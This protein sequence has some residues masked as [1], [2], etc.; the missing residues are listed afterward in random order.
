MMVVST[1]YR[2]VR[3]VNWTKLGEIGP[4][5]LYPERFTAIM[6][7]LFTLALMVL[8]VTQGWGYGRQGSPV[9]SAS[10]G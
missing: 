6:K 7:G 9:H 8:H 1:T 5:K 2:L 3:F 4:V 10:C